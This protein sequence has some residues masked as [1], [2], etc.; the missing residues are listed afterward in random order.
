GMEDDDAE[1]VIKVKGCLW[2]VGN[3]GSMDLGA[4]FLDGTGVVRDVVA[5]AEGCSVMSLRGT[6]VFVLGMIS[7]SLH[8]QEILYDLGWDAA[9]NVRGESNGFCMPLRFERLFSVGH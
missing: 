3:V 1:A 2:A 6:A 7:R 9:V 4:P 8:G 5:I